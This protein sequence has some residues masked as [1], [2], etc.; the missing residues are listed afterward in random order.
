[1]K[2]FILVSPFIYCLATLA[3]WATGVDVAYG[4][5]TSVFSMVEKSISSAGQTRYVNCGSQIVIETY[6]ASSEDWVKIN[7]KKECQEKT[8]IPQRRMAFVFWHSVTLSRLSFTVR[9]QFPILV[10]SSFAR[11]RVLFNNLSSLKTGY[12]KFEYT[13]EGVNQLTGICPLVTRGRAL[14]FLNSPSKL[15]THPQAR[16]PSLFTRSLLTPI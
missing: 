8:A 10:E 16:G 13:R 1:M 5:G 15:K 4:Q 2:K 9:D 3:L 6:S 14:I 12:G 11:V 7:N